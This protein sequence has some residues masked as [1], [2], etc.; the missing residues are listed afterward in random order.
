MSSKR[1]AEPE[2]RRHL[3][4]MAT[5]VLISA[6]GAWLLFEAYRNIEQ[7]PGGL[8]FVMGT[9]GMLFVIG[10]VHKLFDDARRALRDEKGKLIPT[11][12]HPRNN[13]KNDDPPRDENG[14][15]DHKAEGSG[16]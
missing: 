11:S 3:P 14:F 16:W 6:A 8:L 2:V 5:S 13:D 4:G 7:L 12:H 15:L 1:E 9:F 10:G